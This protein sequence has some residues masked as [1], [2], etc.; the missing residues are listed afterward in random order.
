MAVQQATSNAGGSLDP[1]QVE[2]DRI[3]KEKPTLRSLYTDYHK[4][5]IATCPDGPLLDIGGGTAHVKDV[6]SGVTS[7]DLLPFPGIDVVCDAHHLPFSDGHFAGIIMIDVLH[8]LERPVE[9]LNEACR[10][11]RAGGVLAMIEPGMSTIAYPFYRYLHQEPADMTADPFS[12]G[13]AQGARDPYDANQAIPTLLFNNDANH[14][15]LS[16]LVPGLKSRSVEWLSLFAYPLSGGF[17]RWCLCPSRLT[18]ALVHFEDGLPRRM[19]AFFGFRI[20]VTM[21]KPD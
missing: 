20:F 7:V 12:V 4:R 15:R 19:R 21:Q 18:E 11:L 14:C 17:K 3:W 8:H 13:T 2:R 1:R 16:R 6:R 10:V 5:L 9:F